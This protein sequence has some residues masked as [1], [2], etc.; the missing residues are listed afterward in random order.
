M[1][2]IQANTYVHHKH[3][4][5]KE[6]R[7]NTQFSFSMRSTWPW[8]QLT[9]LH[10]D[11]QKPTHS[12]FKCVLYI[13]TKKPTNKHMCICKTTTTTD[14]AKHAFLNIKY[15]YLVHNLVCSMPLCI[16]ASSRIVKICFD[17]IEMYFK[18]SAASRL[19]QTLFVMQTYT[20]YV[21]CY[22]CKHVCW[23]INIYVENEIISQR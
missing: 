13:S 11:T 20:Y 19:L 14:F 2:G 5:T 1:H 8:A 10:T 9:W 23:F 15:A 18:E 4:N 21:H 3:T 16:T 7:K 12:C 17:L 6:R 22:V